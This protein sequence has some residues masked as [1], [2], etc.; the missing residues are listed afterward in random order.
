MGRLQGG[1][2]FPSP[3]EQSRVVGRGKGWGAMGIGGGKAATLGRLRVPPTPVR[4]A[5]AIRT[6]P[7]H[8]FA[9]GGKSQQPPFGK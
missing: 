8:R 2:F 4:I 7:P 6:D 3:H 5:V 9:G 1:L